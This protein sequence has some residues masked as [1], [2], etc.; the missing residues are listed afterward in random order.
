VCLACQTLL[1]GRSEGDEG[2]RGLTE[3]EEGAGVIMF[4]NPKIREQR[5]G[6]FTSRTW[7]EEPNMKNMFVLFTLLSVIAVFLDC[8]GSQQAGSPSAPV[9]PITTATPTISM[10]GTWI[11]TTSANGANSAS[12]VDLVPS[13]CSVTLDW[14]YPGVDDIDTTFTLFGSSC[15]IADN[16]SGLGSISG[17]T[18][19][20]YPLQIVLVSAPSGSFLNTAS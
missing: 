18:G 8:G 3:N 19:L 7:P 5:W 14:D 13:T 20:Y 9:T 6:G 2:R 4:P 10:Q 1:T 12:Q 16:L 11:I 15:F 17:Q